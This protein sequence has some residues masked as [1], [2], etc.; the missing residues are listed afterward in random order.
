MKGSWAA[1][2]GKT[3]ENNKLLKVAICSHSRSAPQASAA[4][5]QR[6]RESTPARNFRCHH[7]APKITLSAS[8]ILVFVS[9]TDA[10][11]KSYLVLLLTASDFIQM[12]ARW[13]LSCHVSWDIARLCFSQAATKISSV[14]TTSNVMTCMA[15]PSPKM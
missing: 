13:Q 6:T 15:Q 9:C 10:S 1:Q 14:G 3:W 7:L 5:S 11:Q 4:A 2:T 8:P 12:E